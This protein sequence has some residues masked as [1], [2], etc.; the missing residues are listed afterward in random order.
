MDNKYLEV[1][2]A[3]EIVKEIKGLKKKNMR[4]SE[5]T[6][7]MDFEFESVRPNRHFYSDNVNDFQDDHEGVDF[8]IFRRAYDKEEFEGFQGRV[9]RIAEECGRFEE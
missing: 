6:T 1:Q 2:K 8:K 5:T 3:F 7:D 9:I 4:S